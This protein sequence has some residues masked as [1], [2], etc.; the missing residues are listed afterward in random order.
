[1]D[2]L[3]T[4]QSLWHRIDGGDCVVFMATGATRENHYLDCSAAFDVKDLEAAWDEWRGV[5]GNVHHFDW[6]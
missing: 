6:I 5:D 3:E 4:Y 1:M 2:T